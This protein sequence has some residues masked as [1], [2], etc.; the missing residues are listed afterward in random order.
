MGWVGVCSCH[1]ARQRETRQLGIMG[2]GLIS[3]ASN[4]REGY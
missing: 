2:G 1:R 3:V 4:V